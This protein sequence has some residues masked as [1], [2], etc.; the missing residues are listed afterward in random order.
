MNRK[1]TKGILLQ[2]ASPDASMN[3]LF[4]SRKIR[5]DESYTNRLT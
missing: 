1:Q 2:V 4:Y 5:T 3:G